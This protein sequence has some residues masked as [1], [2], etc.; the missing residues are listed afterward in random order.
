MLE[1]SE[2]E[3]LMLTAFL[4]LPPTQALT[5][6]CRKKREKTRFRIGFQCLLQLLK[7]VRVESR[8]LGSL[9][10]YLI[11]AFDHGCIRLCLDRVIVYLRYILR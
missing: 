1:E 5:I 3:T 7:D 9:R 10:R 2:H 8:R 4:F 6:L 11:S